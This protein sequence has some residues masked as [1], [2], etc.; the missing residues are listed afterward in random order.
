MCTFR[1]GSRRF[2]SRFLSQWGCDGLKLPYLKTKAI[3]SVKWK[4]PKAEMLILCIILGVL[5]LYFIH[6]ATRQPYR[7]LEISYITLRAY[8]QLG[9]SEQ[10][11]VRELLQIAG[12]ISIPKRER[13]EAKIKMVQVLYSPQAIQDFEE[14]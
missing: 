4:E 8:E 1:K 10:W 12:D 2:N 7:N 3:Y 14:L 13:L 9:F 6:Y 5:L 11:Q